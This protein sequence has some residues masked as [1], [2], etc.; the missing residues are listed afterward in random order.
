MTE[1]VERAEDPIAVRNGPFGS[2]EIPCASKDVLQLLP[3]KSIRQALQNLAEGIFVGAG[4]SSRPGKMSPIS[5]P[6]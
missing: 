2:R 3:R 6:E 5:I 1:G 4:R